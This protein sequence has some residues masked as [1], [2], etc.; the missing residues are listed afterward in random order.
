MTKLLRSGVGMPLTTSMGRLFDGV[1]S[2][3]GVCQVASFE[4]QGAVALQ[5]AAE[6]GGEGV[7]QEPDT[8]DA[9]YPIP[10]RNF[11][12]EPGPAVA[13]WRPLIQQISY[14]VSKGMSPMLIAYSFH[15]ALA[16][17][18]QSVAERAA[19]PR[20][21]LTGG[22]FQNVLLVRL[23]RHRLE[24]AGFT[25]YTHQQVPPNDGGLALGQV[26]IAAHQLVRSK[27]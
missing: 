4:G 1:A 22:C 11:Q 25:V 12:T 8:A 2:I 10:L 3:T 24:Q 27:G 21:V 16:D 26:M 19:L 7:R 17:L 5:L 23:V 14:D 18:V 9:R 20:V 15:Q 6:R 13:D